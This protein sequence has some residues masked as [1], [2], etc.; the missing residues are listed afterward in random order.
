[1]ARSKISLSLEIFNLA[2]NLDFFDLWVLWVL[3][4]KASDIFRDGK[5]W[6]IA[7]RRFLINTSRAQIENEILYIFQGKHPEFRRMAEFREKKLLN[8]MA[9]VFP[10]LI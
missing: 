5:T 2:R 3:K 10:L 1:M 4:G 8:A 7:K 6:A 9:Q